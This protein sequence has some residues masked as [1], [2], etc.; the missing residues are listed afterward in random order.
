MSFSIGIVGLPNVGKSTLFKALTKQSVDIS[1]YPFCTIDPNVGVVAVPD[2]RLDKIA[3]VIN[4][5]KITPTV[6][7]F[8]DIAGLVKNA[9]QGEGLGNQFLAHIREVQVVRDFTNEKI[10]HT[11]EGIDPQRDIE[12]INLELIMKDLETVNKRLE[13]TQKQAR[14]G[15]KKIAQELATLEE[16][17]KILE[18]GKLINSEQVRKQVRSPTPNLLGVGLLKELSKELG[19][20][21]AKPMIYV[22][23]ISGGPSTRSD[24]VGARSGNIRSA[25]PLL[26]EQAS[27]ASA[28]KAICLELKLELELSELSKEEQR[29][30]E[31]PPSQLDQL[32]KSCYQALD[33]ITFYT[34]KGGQETRAWTL[35][36]NSKVTQAGG[37][38]H[39]DFEEKFIRA[40]VINWQKLIKT[41]NWQIAREKGL[42][43]TEG[44]KYIVQNGDVIEFK[45]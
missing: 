5:Q 45:I 26:P 34:I 14:S 7:E 21:T 27:E 39:T 33:L 20:I 2:K 22:F 19:L 29:E 44:K 11:E 9:H 25:E 38:V 24:F 1:N 43:R 16:I 13:K 40:E 15:D 42:L 41:G 23:N 28:L 32:I 8:V 6:I 35:K 12:I 17:K 4:P 36:N 10:T 3:Q 18:Q 37:V 31:L 30:L